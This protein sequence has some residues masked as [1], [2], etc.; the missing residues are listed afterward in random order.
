L[1]VQTVEVTR[2]AEEVIVLVELEKG[3]L[4]VRL[5]AGDDALV[6][7]EEPVLIAYVEVVGAEA[8]VAFE[9]PVLIAKV[10]FACAEMV[11]ATVEVLLPS[12]KT[13]PAVLLVV[14]YVEDA[15]LMGNVDTVMEIIDSGALVGSAGREDP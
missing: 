1:V 11:A 6:A 9:E 5:V 10:E 4:T 7:F 2:E 14:A 15:V 3:D 12:K 8:P 13:P